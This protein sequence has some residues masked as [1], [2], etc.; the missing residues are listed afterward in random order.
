MEKFDNSVGIKY[1]YYAPNIGCIKISTA[2]SEK[3]DKEY[4][5]VQAIY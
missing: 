1:L 3:P 4:I 5:S 2:S